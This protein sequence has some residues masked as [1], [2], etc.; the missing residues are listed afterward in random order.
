MKNYHRDEAAKDGNK[1]YD[2]HLYMGDMGYNSNADF[3]LI[4]RVFM[5]PGP[6][7][8]GIV[9]SV[10]TDGV[11]HYTHDSVP[12]ATGELDKFRAGYKKVAEA[13]WTD[14]CWLVP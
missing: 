14:K 8:V 6:V 2:S 5:R 13:A 4:L 9:D 11:T 10:Q 3:Q 12:W 1:H 7:G